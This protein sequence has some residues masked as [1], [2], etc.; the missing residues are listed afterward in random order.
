MEKVVITGS[1][2]FVGKYVVNLA[3]KRGLEVHLLVRDPKKAKTLYGQSIKAYK[4]DDFADKNIVERI[5]KEIN[6]DYIIHLIGIIQE[7][8][9]KGI[10][11]EKVHYEYSKVLYDVAKELSLKKIVH[12]SALG[13]DE[14]APSKY[15]IT[16]LKA[17]KE[18]IKSGLPYV[19]IRPSFI[20][21]PEQLLFVKLKPILKKT[22]LL[23]F[24]SFGSYSFQPVDVRDVAEAFVNALRYEKDEVFE[25][26]GDER[27]S[28]N[29]LIRD[30]VTAFGKRVLFFPFP[31]I[32]LKIFAP[33]QY[34]MMWKDNVCGFGS[35]G[36]AE[37]ILGRPSI[38][39]KES[40]KW[41]SLN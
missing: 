24:P 28:F 30:F 31:K 21:G 20:V 29:R 10:T 11:F 35:V 8:K 25:L 15:H 9:S 5:L 1:T 26:C 32:F 12:M 2:G 34:L 38:P 23:L 13:V 37:Q 6:P 4:V 39:Y 14:R 41:A 3:I 7:N 16:K 19:I 36:S 17:E 40:I 27:V 22:P 33:E 18:L